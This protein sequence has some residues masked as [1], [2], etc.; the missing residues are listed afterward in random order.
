MTANET[1][2]GGAGSAPARRTPFPL[3]GWSAREVDGWP[4]RRIGIPALTVQGR[5]NTA[6]VEGAPRFVRLD[7]QSAAGKSRKGPVLRT[8]SIAGS[9][10][11]WLRVA[12]RTLG[13]DDVEVAVT[14]S[15]ASERSYNLSRIRSSSWTTV[16][17]FATGVGAVLFGLNATDISYVSSR[18][19]AWIAA[20]LLLIGTICAFLGWLRSE[21]D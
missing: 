6:D 17:G 5:S 12:P 21:P 1:A 7:R 8:E 10:D 14:L 3:D 19:V 18:T 4:Q 11:E 2:S 16:A 13:R 20:A 9:T 15:P